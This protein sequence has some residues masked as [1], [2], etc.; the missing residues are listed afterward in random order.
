VA[1]KKIRAV[2][3]TMF[4]DAFASLPFRRDDELRILDVGCGLGFFSY[5]SAEF[6]NNAQITGIDTFK[7]VSLKE[8]SLEKANENASILGL[9]GRIDFK[10]EI[11]YP[12]ECCWL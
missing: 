9:S 6:Y 11:L 5:V 10:K 1:S 3:K 2:V 7:H 8:S 12:P 4:T